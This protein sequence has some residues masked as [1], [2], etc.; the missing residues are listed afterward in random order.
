MKNQ[1]LK[2]VIFIVIAILFYIGFVFLQFSI[3]ERTFA[4]IGISIILFITSLVIG[5]FI[6]KIQSR[7]EFQEQL[8]SKAIGSIR[9]LKDIEIL[10]KRSLTNISAS[11]ND[12]S[13]TMFNIISD[14]VRSAIFDWTDVLE[15]DFKKIQEL[16]NKKL[17]LI[18][19]LS[20]K[21]EDHEEGKKQIEELEK[22]ISRLQNSIPPKLY[23]SVT[24]KQFTE[25]QFFQ[26]QERLNFL[27]ASR[28]E[29]EILIEVLDPKLYSIVEKN[30]PI[31]FH[32]S[33]TDANNGLFVVS[34]NDIK[35]R[36]GKVI[37]IFTEAVIFDSTYYSWLSTVLHHYRNNE[38]IVLDEYS[39]QRKSTKKGNE[40]LVKLPTSK[41]FFVHG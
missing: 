24:E 38:L 34:G 8:R 40:I 19:A 32:Y 27:A 36:I 16:E 18:N 4:Y 13:I 10:V 22:E 11:T 17:A 14:S 31:S 25:M 5:L 30:E 12:I 26:T 37:N 41:L 23:S 33:R 39:Y 20:Y 29:Y 21:S 7:Q 9:R 3:Q 35:N 28:N 6:Q 2:F 1:N 15:E